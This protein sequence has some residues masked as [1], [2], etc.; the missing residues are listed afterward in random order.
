MQLVGYIQNLDELH[1]KCW[2]V[3]SKMLVGCIQNLGGLH[4]KSWR[5][6]PKIWEDYIQ[7]LS[8]LHPQPW[9]VTSKILVWQGLEHYLNVKVIE[10]LMGNHDDEEVDGVP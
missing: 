2:W 10:K 1:S 7:N 3:T 6:T 8:V 9:W 5:I 4:P